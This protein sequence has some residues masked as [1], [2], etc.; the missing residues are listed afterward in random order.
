MGLL[1]V[2]ILGFLARHATFLQK[3][4]PAVLNLAQSGGYRA[5]PMREIDD[6][7]ERSNLATPLSEH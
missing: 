1:G 2:R 5:K 7:S 3:L 4:V 6:L